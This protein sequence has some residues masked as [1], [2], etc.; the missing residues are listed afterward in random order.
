MQNIPKMNARITQ[1]YVSC[2][3]SFRRLL[4]GTRGITL[5]FPG[6]RLTDQEVL[7]E[8]IREGMFTTYGSQAS[9]LIWSCCDDRCGETP[10]CERGEHVPSNA[11]TKRQRRWSRSVI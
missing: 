2:L 10:G 6:E 5:A 7:A 11:P 1:V 9:D 3:D 4:M 8:Y